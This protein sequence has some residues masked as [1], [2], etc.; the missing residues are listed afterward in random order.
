MSVFSTRLF[1]PRSEGQGTLAP[2]PLFIAGMISPVEGG[3]A[4]INIAVAEGDPSGLLT[5]IDPYLEMQEGDRVTVIVEGERVLELPVGP[6][7]VGKRLF[8]YLPKA[9][10]QPEWVENI[11]FQLLR[12]GATVPEESVPLRLRVKLNLPGGV[13]KEPHL[14]GHSELLRPQ[15]PQD[16][17]DNGVDAEWAAKG[18]PVTIAHY[19]DRAARDTVVLRWGSVRIPRLISEDEAQDKEPIQIVVDQAA[20]LAGGDS[21][22]LELI[23]EVFD[24]VWNYSSDWSRSTSLKVEAGAWR[25]AP[26]IIK[27]AVNGEIDLIALGP[28]DV[29]VQ[30]TMDGE[31][32]ALGDTIE[33]TWIGTPKMGAP[34]VHTESVLINNL[35]KVL[36]LKVPNA[37]IRAIASGTGDTAYVLRKADGGP[38]LSSKRTFAKI[39]GELSELPSPNILEAVG[40]LLDSRLEHAWVRLGPYPGMAV[41]DVVNLIWQGTRADGRPYVHEEQLDVSQG[42]VDKSIDILV[43]AEHISVLDNGSLSLYYRVSNERAVTYDVRESARSYFNVLN[44]RHELPAPVVEEADGDVLDPEVIT[45]NGATLRVDY[46]ETEAGDVLTYYWQSVY[47]EGTT[48]DWVPI[49]QASKGLPVRFRIASS[50]IEVSRGTT[51]NTL[52]SLKRAD[53]TRIS[54]VFELYIGKPIP[55]A[56]TSVIDSWGQVV[57]GGFTV[58]TAVTLS[59]TARVAMS[60]ELLDGESV[61]GQAGANEQGVWRFPMVNLAPKRYDLKARA[62]Y[63]NGME[64]QVWGFTVVVDVIPTITGV[65]DSRRNIANGGATV[66]TSVTL[67]GSASVGQEIELFEGAASWG[68][69]KVDSEGNW[70]LPKAGLVTRSYSLMA[71]ALYGDGHESELRTFQ[72]VTEVSPTITSVKDSRGELQEG[73]TTVD[74]LVTLAGKASIDQP[75]EVLDGMDVLDTVQSDDQGN[76]TLIL[77]A[78]AV[79]AYSIKVRAL[80]GNGAQSA[81]RTFRVVDYV[82]PTLDSVRDSKG[83]IAD[84]GATADTSVSLGG[85]ASANEEVEIFEG[86]TS[87]GRVRVGAGGDWT[88]PLT[89]LTP[90]TYGFKAKAVYGEGEESVVRTF[91]VFADIKPS[92][93]SVKDSRGEVA[94]AGTTVET[95]VALTGKASISQ[96]VELFDGA[97]SLAKVTANAGGDWNHSLQGLV[98][99]GYKLK[100]KALYG[101]GHESDIRSFSVVADVAPTLTSVKDAKGEVVEGGFTF[102]GSVSV[103]GKASIGQ[104]VEVFDDATTRG[105]ALVNGS[106]GWT[107]KLTGLTV[108]QYRVK[109]VALYGSGQESAVRRFEVR[110][111]AT[112][113]I[114][115]VVDSAGS[116]IGNGGRT[117]ETALTLQGTAQGGQQVQI[118]DNGAVQQTVAVAANGS[119]QVSLAGLSSMQHNFSAKGLYGSQ[120]VSAAWRVIVEA[121]PPLRIDTS[122]MTLSGRIYVNA[123]NGQGPSNRPGGTSGQRTASGGVPPYTYRSS[124]Q[125]VASVNADNGTVLS[126]GNGSTTITVSDKAGQTAKYTVNV[127]GVIR[128]N[129]KGQ[130]QFASA[131]RIATSEATLREIYNQYGGGGITRV[132]LPGGNYFTSNSEH[133]PW[134]I[135]KGVYLNMDNGAKG[136]EAQLG[137]SFHVIQIS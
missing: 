5:V 32:F 117:Y 20:I 53:Q 65:A 52:Y 44:V 1:P 61:L 21:D 15:V 101:A 64:S 129:Y 76:W 7:D 96:Q 11:H 42:A 16:I 121:R 68:R 8:F 19:P 89:G 137:R 80:Y 23:Y 17:I 124:N 74:T 136:W 128:M 127:S 28:K 35:P 57:E 37:D 58:D 85:E 30:V 120:P 81:A 125:A 62:L 108:K 82:F 9:Q 47:A 123:S 86:A 88:L 59:G 113:A 98:V 31:P 131:F 63:G 126:V 56:I 26:P 84:G 72:V 43:N 79:K 10:F 135:A 83:E 116:V 75:L 119:W 97:T 14:P 46:A 90:K 3:D 103:S 38:A 93:A 69:V 27:E 106:G 4:G 109:A 111:G 133:H 25:L 24:E 6:S 36:D 112:P 70:R 12:F 122:A 29:T 118:L 41:G 39:V 104:R 67:S 102:D 50:L 105:T 130:W 87:R 110:Q 100:A 91:T 71:K 51:I 48:S 34:L 99:R 66:D 114:T 77:R 55:V 13:D 49:T 18:V 115:R 95:S 92:I 33:F 134:P 54:S 78:L 2:R 94:E 132:G 40:A 73:K 45:P 107:L 60:V 22:A